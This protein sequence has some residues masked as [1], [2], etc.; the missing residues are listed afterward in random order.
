ML[1]NAVYQEQV[2]D[3]DPDVQALKKRLAQKYPNVADHIAVEY[4]TPQ[5]FDM[6]SGNASNRALPRKANLS[7]RCL[8]AERQLSLTECPHVIA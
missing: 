3:L 4:L 8:I 1:Y 7:D 6:V 5:Q 2:I